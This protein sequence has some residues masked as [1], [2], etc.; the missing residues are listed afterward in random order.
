[1]DEQRFQDEYVKNIAKTISNFGASINKLN[2]TTNALNTTIAVM[3]VTLSTVL[4]VQKQQLAEAKKTN[5]RVT[6]LELSHQSLRE[7]QEINTQS[8]GFFNKL[9]KETPIT[10]II[11]L[12]L[13]A[14]IGYL[15]KE[16]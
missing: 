10:T 1:M 7:K 16:L 13:G 14:V 11:T 3:Q 9:F 15:M 6:Q 2:D 4:E 12:V 8:I 5:G